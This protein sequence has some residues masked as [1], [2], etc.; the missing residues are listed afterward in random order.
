MGGGAGIGLL[1][2]DLLMSLRLQGGA[3]GE[4]QGE[5]FSVPYLDAFSHIIPVALQK[6]SQSMEA[7]AA[8]AVT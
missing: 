8:V 3:W 1:P 7:A 2:P 6:V 4:G 5:G